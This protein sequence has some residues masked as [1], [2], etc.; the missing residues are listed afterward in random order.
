MM[1]AP[2][3]NKKSPLAVMIIVDWLP[4]FTYYDKL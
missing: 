4:I 3:C 2:P 1:I